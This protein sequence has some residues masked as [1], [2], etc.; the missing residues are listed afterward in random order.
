MN[1]NRYKGFRYITARM[2]E[3][4][5]IL[6]HLNDTIIHTFSLHQVPY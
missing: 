1:V 4:M 2:Y 3:V 5:L 6:C